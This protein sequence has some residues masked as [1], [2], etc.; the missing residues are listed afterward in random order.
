MG[1][2]N[3]TCT[4]SG[5][6]PH[7][8]PKNL[9]IE[10]LRRIL[11]FEVQQLVYL[12]YDTFITGAAMGVDLWGAYAVL[13]INKIIDKKIKLISYQPYPG[14]AI[15]FPSDWK[16]LYDFIL[17]KSDSVLCLSEKYTSTCMIERNKKMIELSSRLLAVHD[18][19]PGGTLQTINYATSHGLIIKTVQPPTM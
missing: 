18:G 13:E 3:K 12:G 7:K 19:S 2:K 1:C 8:L 5:L 10:K 14:Q 9:D 16:S 17:K 11:Y 4:I 6:R 15:K